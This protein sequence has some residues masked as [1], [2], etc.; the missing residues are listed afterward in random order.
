MNFC[1]GKARRHRI[2][3]DIARPQ[4]DRKRLDKADDR[5]PAADSAMLAN[6]QQV[7]V[8]A[9]LE[10]LPEKDRELLRWLFYDE[11]DKDEICRE[12]NIDR[13]YLRVLLHRAKARFRERFA[14]QR[15]G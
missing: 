3:G 4:F 2:D 5:R 12:L 10:G 13:G 14:D 1:S 11:R 15:T 6:E 8:K 7:M 9:A